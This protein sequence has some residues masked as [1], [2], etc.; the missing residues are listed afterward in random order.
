VTDPL[1][2]LLSAGAVPTTSYPPT[3]RYA[4]TPVRTFDP[5]DGSP[6]RPYLDRR[7]VP[8]ADRFTVLTEVRIV[9][10]D[11][12]DL[13]A[14]RHLGDAHLWWRLADANGLLDPRELTDTVGARL[15]ITLAEG[16]PGGDD[17]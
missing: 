9:D 13:L 2:E 11:R 14:E 16:I 15:R 7:T 5:G 17:D 6:P 3:S 12:R 1:Q 4:D 8:A 10:G